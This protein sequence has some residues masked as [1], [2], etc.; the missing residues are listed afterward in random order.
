MAEQ[1]Y[2]SVFTKQGLALLTEAIQNGT[3]LG[4]T[5][6]AFGDGGGSLPVPN[7]NFTSMVREVHRTQLNSLAPDPNNANWLRADAIIASATGGFNIRELGLYAGNVLVAYSNYPPTY[8]PNPSD[9]TARIMSFR[10]ILQIDNTANFDLVIDPDVVLATIQKVEDVK[11]EIYQNTVSTIESVLDLK[12]LDVCDGRI[13]YA[14]AYYKNGDVRGGGDFIY[15]VN[16][17][18][19]DI[20]E[21]FTFAGRNNIGRWKRQIIGTE[22]NTAQAGII[23]DGSDQSERIQ[24]LFD[25]CVYTSLKYG[26]TWKLTISGL[27]QRVFCSKPLECNLT[28]LKL[29]DIWFEFTLQNQNSISTTGIAITFFGTDNWISSKPD[30]WRRKNPSKPIQNVRINGNKANNTCGAYFRP[31]NSEGSFSNYIFELLT[32]EGFD[33]NLV[34]TTHCYIL[35]FQNC[36]FTQASKYILTDS[37]RIGLT[38]AMTDMGENL[39]FT[40]CSFVNSNAICELSTESWYNFHNC[41]FDYCGKSTDTNGWFRLLGNVGLNFFSCHFESGNDYAQLGKYMFYTTGLISAVNIFGGTFMFGEKNI[42]DY[43]FY[44]TNPE[45]GNFQVDGLWVWAPSVAKEAWSNTNMGRFKVFTNTKVGLNVAGIRG[46]QAINKSLTIDPKFEKSFLMQTPYDY[47]FV[48]DLNDSSKSQLNNTSLNCT[49]VNSADSLSN[50]YNSL[51]AVISSE[52]QTLFCIVKRRSGP[53]T[54]HTPAVK[55]SHFSDHN[56]NIFIKYCPADVRFKTNQNGVSIPIVNT[57]R[58][59]DTNILGFYEE[60]NVSTAK[61]S[62]N[63]YFPA[64]SAIKNFESFDYWLVQINFAHNTKLDYFVTGLEVY[65][66][67]V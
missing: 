65:E 25:A 63:I 5:S 28:L 2:Y 10:M 40:N 52:N 38:E 53:K 42:N 21:I 18:T 66:M 58:F 11:L 12:K 43:V 3:K 62:T 67:D 54:N 46:I 9:G 29:K 47:W 8:K 13:V 22:I 64:L 39:S 56:A 48:N 57:D 15:D 24:K 36:V 27:E 55:L 33:Y 26:Y 44:S 30:T 14:K 41:S 50:K 20:D 6:M 7:E 1:I 31:N 59:A 37:N 45:N 17:N 34:L 61:S 35:N 51:K 49:F 19:T 23:N 60:I 4:I 16:D 32:I